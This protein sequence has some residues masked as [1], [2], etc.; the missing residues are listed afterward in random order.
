MA[1]RIFRILEIRGQLMGDKPVK[2]WYNVNKVWTF[3]EQEQ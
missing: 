1:R 3:S 2:L